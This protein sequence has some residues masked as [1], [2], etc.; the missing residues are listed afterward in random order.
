METWPAILPKPLHGYQAEPNTAGVL[1]SE[2]STGRARQRLVADVRDDI[3]QIEWLFTPQQ[4]V[5]FEN[6][7]GVRCNKVDWFTGP[8]HDGEGLKDGTVRLVNGAYRFQQVS[9]SKDFSVTASLEV[10]DRQFD[11][12]GLLA[13][14]LYPN[15]ID[16]YLGNLEDAWNNW[17][18][19]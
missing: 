5:I 19:E 4:L 1:R 17:Y 7:I 2:S 12:Y 16:Q 9:N 15:T 14:Y 18:T 6:F 3:F 13:A 8:Y 11:E 10:Q